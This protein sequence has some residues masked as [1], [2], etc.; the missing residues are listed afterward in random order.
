LSGRLAR[1]AREKLRPGGWLAAYCST[2]LMA[3]VMG[4]LDEHLA[5]YWSVAVRCTG[6]PRQCN[7][8]RARAGWKPILIY[9]KPPRR[10]PPDWWLGSTRT[11]TLPKSL[12]FGF[13]RQPSAS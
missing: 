5:Y 9:Q 6:M 11:P 10:L 2:H 7:A 1:L 13:V 12:V 4:Q 3:Q 8:F